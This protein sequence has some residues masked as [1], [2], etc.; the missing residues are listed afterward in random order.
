[1]YLQVHDESGLLSSDEEPQDAAG[2]QHQQHDEDQGARHH[3]VPGGGHAVND[4]R[5]PQ[6]GLLHPLGRHLLGLGEAVPPE[7]CL[8]GLLVSQQ[9]QAD[10][11]LLAPLTSG[12]ELLAHNFI[13]Y[14][15]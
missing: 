10:V 15:I 11:V 13:T 2:V 9:L 4:L 8:R 1:M 3:L 12:H 5:A 7:R 14:F 6:G